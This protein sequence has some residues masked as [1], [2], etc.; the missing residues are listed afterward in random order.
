[1]SKEFISPNKNDSFAFLRGLDLQDLLVQTESYLLEY[2]DN[3]NLSDDVT[4]G[5]EIEYEG[6]SEK[7]VDKYVK[8]KLFRWNSSYDGSLNSGGEIRSPIMSDRMEYW[9]ELKTICNYLTKRGADTLHNAGGH[10]H[11]G[12]YVLRDDIGAWRQFLK[13]YIAYENVLFRFM[14]GDKISGRKELLK[15]APPIAEN[16]Y[17]YLNKINNAGGLSNIADV[18][19]RNSRYAALNLRNTNFCSPNRKYD[20][21][22]LEFRGPN[23]TTNAVIWQN[24]INTFAKMLLSSREKVMDEEFLDYKLEYEFLP[25]SGNE[26]LYNDVNLKN[27]L[28]FVDLVFDNNLD[29]VYFLRQYLKNFQENYGI[30]KAVKAKRFVK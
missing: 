10:V 17:N 26:Y 18:G 3:L 27:A 1:M 21:N 29:K 13:L 15:Y 5:V 24:N 30:Q 14:Y 8:D 7:L 23:A 28:E 20:K 25:Y 22:T 4:F 6:I 12:A 9:K 2:R 11:I 19:V 16:L